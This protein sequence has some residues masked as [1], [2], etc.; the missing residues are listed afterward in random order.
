MAL[1]RLG[2][3]CLGLTIALAGLLSGGTNV[4]GG[5]ELTR[6]L[7]PDFC[8]V[9][10][11]H[12]ERIKTS[13]L[14]VAAN[15]ALPK[16]M[17]SAD[18]TPALMAA[19]ATQKNLPP[20][21]DVAKLVKLTAGKAVRR[22]VIFIDPMPAK[23]LPA[24]PGVI[25][26]FGE[27]IDTEGLL[28]AISSG[29][30]PVEAVG[31][32][33]KKLQNPKPGQP[34]LAAVA[35]D[36]RTLIAGMDA[37]VLKMLAKDQGVQPLLKQLQHT[38]FDHDIIVEF[39]AEPLLAKVAKSAGKSPE[40]VLA[41]MGDGKTTWGQLAKDVKSASLTL[42]F[43]GETLFHG[44]VGAA[45]P[46][47]AAAMSMMATMG[48]AGGKA[49]F[50][51]MKKGPLPMVPPAALEVISK[52]GDEMFAGLTIKAEGPR[53]VVDL[54]MPASLPDALKF[55]AQMAKNNPAARPGR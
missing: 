48:V 44:E 24:A 15:S 18:P 23:D 25:V 14:A 7:S 3:T 13:T 27:D 53:L 11:I 33:Y 40:E 20:G 36:P 45:K 9:V 35:L 26:Q 1:Q 12:P 10:V 42:D 50:A 32:K 55:A 37:T 29:W 47:S 21:L 2:M 31:T 49:K 34:D 46:E 17:A 39:L 19:L 52:L 5:A 54:P 43:S 38:S 41:S 16:E 22:I 30:E 6:Y 4:A 8:A 28:S 51:E